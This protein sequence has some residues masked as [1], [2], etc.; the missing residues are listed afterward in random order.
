MEVGTRSKYI[1]ARNASHVEGLWEQF[2][3]TCSVILG[4]NSHD[5]Y[6]DALVRCEWVDHLA[7]SNLKGGSIET[8][9]NT[10]FFCVVCAETCP[11]G[12]HLGCGH[13]L[14][15]AGWMD[16]LSAKKDEG[17]T[18][19][20]RCWKKDCS[21][22]VPLSWR[23][24]S[25]RELKDTVWKSYMQ[26]SREPLAVCPFKCEGIVRWIS[27]PNAPRP[28][29]VSVTCNCGER[30]CWS[31]RNTD[32]FPVLCGVAD[33]WTKLATQAQAVLEEPK[34]S[35]E[36]ATEKLEQ[37]KR[38]SHAP[39]PKCHVLIMK[40]GGCTHLTCTVC[41]HEFCWIC[42]AKWERGHKCDLAESPHDMLVQRRKLLLAFDVMQD[43]KVI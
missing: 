34:K 7:L 38:E 27:G 25:E 1:V 15:K 6:Y 31:C 8:R 30:W 19:I 9:Q 5:L 16:Y 14:C 11:E 32:H 35:K 18:G 24:L 26:V 39:C 2:D 20:V 41:N 17:N 10:E 29:L 28:K 21:R 22:V 37:I 36:A 13:A 23:K 12:V 40:N 43:F 3:T 42:L 4:D 33:A